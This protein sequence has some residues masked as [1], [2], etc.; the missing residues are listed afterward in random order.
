MSGNDEPEGAATPKAARARPWPGLAVGLAGLIGLVLLMASSRRYGFSVP[1]GSLLALLSSA[2]FLHACGTFSRGE[3]APEG[4]AGEIELG[5]L[6]GPLVEVLAGVA[7]LVALLRL[8]VA[9]SLTL[10]VSGVW[11]QRLAI[12]LPALLVPAIALWLTTAVFRLGR[13]LGAWRADED[14][15][16][17]PL[18]A[19]HGFWVIVATIVL[20]LPLLGSYSLSDPWETHYG[21]VARELLSRD[22]W[23]SLWWAQEGWFWSKP[24]LNFWAQGLT[25]SLLGVRYLPDEMLAAA[26]SGRFPQPEWG[27]RLPVFALTLCASY[28]SY[29]GAAKAFGRRAGLLGVLVLLTMPYWYLIAHQSMTDMP[30]AA[31]MVAGMGLV[32]YGLCSDPDARVGSITVRWGARRWELSVA[33]LLLGVVLLSVLPQIA[34]LFSRNLTL[35]PRGL[36]VHLDTFFSGSGEQNCGLPGNAACKTERPVHDAVLSLGK[37]GIDFLQPSWLAL[38]WSA[39]VG[40]LT[41]MNRGERRVQRLAFLGGWYFVAISAM[42]KGAPGLVLPLFSVLVFVG[43]TR[44]W[45]DLERLELPA[46]VLLVACVVAPWYVAMYVRHGAPFIDRLVFH[47]MYARAFVHVHDTNTGDDVSFRYYVWQLGYGIFPWTGLG[48]AGLLWWW[49]EPREGRRTDGATF[50]ALW[51]VSAFAMFSVTLTKFHHYILPAV[52][53]IAM[54]TGLFLDRALEADRLPR[55]RQLARY[56]AGLSVGALLSTYAVLRTRPGSPLGTTYGD[57]HVPPAAH[58]W[59]ALFAGLA[60]VGLLAWTVRRAWF[61]AAGEPA[62][63]EERITRT[64]LGA[65]GIASAVVVGL[66]GRDL[67]SDVKGDVEGS[68]RL[69]HLFTYNYKRPWPESLDFGATLLAFTVVSAA[70]S[71]LFAWDRLRPH[72]AALMLSL[73]GVWTVWG[74][75]VYLYRCAPHWGQRETLLAYYRDRSGPADYLVS[76]QMNWK[77]ENFYTGNRTPAFVSSGQKFKD[78][79]EE[80]RKKGVKRIYFTTEH[81][82]TGTLKGEIGQHVRFETITSKE[83]N[84]KFALVRVDF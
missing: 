57:S 78:W 11:G 65:L 18:L 22:D 56:A 5:S 6:R 79:I 50:F 52:P 4:A 42:A 80:Q 1:V 31:P 2:G 76:Y 49:R 12:A 13:H 33:H 19:R 64:Q 77:G 84:N 27:A 51:F 41:W 63:L 17:R 67:F 30:Y 3:G 20:Y 36:S 26:A 48:V 70:V 28:L 10:G 71:L 62:S 35:G 55:G 45:G 75:D 47:D 59:L 44:R 46:L 82:R 61:S 74:V 58:P 15:V 24:I 9:G 83:L 38:V 43:A 29:K 8:A 73:A 34:Y 66:A 54:L 40:A 81:G 68:A 25:F 53:P 16:D 72:A 23:I 21:E 69:M 7:G 39:V 32:L 60:G 14:G 37:G